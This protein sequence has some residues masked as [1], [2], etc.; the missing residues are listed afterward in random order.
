MLKVCVSKL[1]DWANSLPRSFL[2]HTV[3]MFKDKIYKYLVNLRYVNFI[4]YLEIAAIQACDMIGKGPTK[5]VPDT[6]LTIK[7]QIKLYL[8]QLKEI[9]SSMF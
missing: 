8:L 1:S 5:V 4:I 2:T 9:K 3:S 6:R 7:I